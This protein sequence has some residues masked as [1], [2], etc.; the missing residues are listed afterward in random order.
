MHDDQRASE[1][2]P[3]DVALLVVG[4]GTA[5]PGGAA[6]TRRVAALVA[7]ALPAVPVELGFLEVIGPS[8]GEALAT[9]A[10]RGCRE[11]VAAPLLLFAAGHAR[12]DVPEALAAGAAAC[13]VVVR[14]AEPIGCHPD[15]VA[16]SA[17]RLAA[18]GGCADAALVVV[19]RGSSG[20]TAAEQLMAYAHAVLAEPGLAP[21]RFLGLAF[22]AAARPT[23][24]EGLDAAAASGAR[25]VV[26][27][28]HL[29]FGGHVEEQIRA[30]VAAARAAHPAI[31]WVAA[32]RLGAEPAVARALV[33]RAGEVVS[34]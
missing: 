19:G 23:L 34:D 9:L 18:V 7:E 8:L 30:A 21:P 27:L 20:G 3:R 2:W 14:Q 29:L 11:V 10:Q 16:L 22:A 17:R 1:S 12:R 15:L 6:E 5:D 25:R 4:H 31:E 26:V 32:S 28:P 13:G 24:P 33:A